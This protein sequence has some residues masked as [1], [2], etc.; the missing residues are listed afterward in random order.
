MREQ[1]VPPALVPDL[2]VPISTW[3]AISKPPHFTALS[4]WPSMGTWTGGGFFGDDGSIHLR[5]SNLTP[6]ANAGP[7]DVAVHGISRTAE[8]NRSASFGSVESD[9]KQSELAIALTL[10]GANRIHWIDLD[11]RRGTTFACD[12]CVYRLRQDAALEDIGLQ[13]ELIADF[14]DLR[15]EQVAPTSAALQW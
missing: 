12:G 9:A 4:I 1:E 2:T 11:K 8:I 13:A 10:A 7:P 6:I 15:F 5:E 14:S 3:T